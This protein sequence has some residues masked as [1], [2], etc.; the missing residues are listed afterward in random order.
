MKHLKKL[1]TPAIALAMVIVMALP[2]FAA[3]KKKISLPQN[4]V[5]V[6]AGTEA[7]ENCDNPSARCHSVV[8][9]DALVDLFSKIQCRVL[10]NAGVSI[11]KNEVTTLTEGA[12]DYT[13]IQLKSA[14]H[15]VNSVTFQ[16][17]GNSSAAAD[18]TVSYLSYTPK[19]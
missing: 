11:G 14:Y 17:R 15:G 13:E 3:S 6:T 1:I 4:Q 12:K 16:F 19:K 10:N 8:P 18:A 7:R 5:W 2:A 9:V